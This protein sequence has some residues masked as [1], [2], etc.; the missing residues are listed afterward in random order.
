[1]VAVIFIAVHYISFF[2]FGDTSKNKDTLFSAREEKNTNQQGVLR[3]VKVRLGNVTINAEVAEEESDME[4]GLGKRDS[5]SDDGGMLFAFG[6]PDFWGI[7]MK[8][9]KFPIDIIW[10]DENL[11]VV[12][13]EKDVKPETYP[14]V[15]SPSEKA[16]YVLETNSG[17]SEKNK[18]TVGEQTFV[19]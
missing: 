17:F 10:L 11:K 4:L 1:M 19:E 2:S 14:E 6:V 8:D 15:F 9:M 13:I 7:W 16:M 3:R 5:I 18:I 12:H